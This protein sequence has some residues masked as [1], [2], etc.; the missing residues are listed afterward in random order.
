MEK[1]QT[2]VK[3]V[4]LGL[5]CDSC[6]GKSSICKVFTGMEFD[7]E[8]MCSIFLDKFEK[9]VTVENEGNIKLVMWD[10]LGQVRYR[11]QAYITLKEV[12]GIILVFDYTSRKSFQNINIWLEEIKDNL[13][14]DIIIV[15]FGNKIDIE[16][17]KW[18]VTSEEAK[19]YSKKMNLML[20]D[21]SAKINQGIN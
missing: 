18:K 5:F 9:K 14:S 13:N 1:A 3:V 6:V 11:N 20:F 17:E 8:P 4:K 21:I 2:C 12:H 10:Q 15:L 16:K 19:E 7:S